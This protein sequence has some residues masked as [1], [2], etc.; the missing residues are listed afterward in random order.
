MPSTPTTKSQVQAY[1]FVLRRMESALVRK[2]PVMLHEPLRS[3]AR[4]TLAG[5]CLAMVIT[6]GFLVF[7]VI[8]Q[9]PSLPTDNPRIVIAEPSGSIYVF[10]PNSRR[11][12]PVFNLASAR[13]LLAALN[14]N[15]QVSTDPKV[16]GDDQLQ[17]VSMGKLTGIPDGPQVLP[18][19]GSPAADWA[20]CDDARNGKLQTTVLAGVSNIGTTLPANQ[21]LLVTGPDGKTYLV[22]QRPHDVNNPDDSPVRAEVDVTD[23]KVWSALGLPPIAQ[24]RKI[25]GA[26]LNAIPEVGQITNP[27]AK[28]PGYGQLGPVA[29]GGLKVGDSYQVVNVGGPTYYY[30]VVSTTSVE[31]VTPTV[32]QIVRYVEGQSG[33]M[34]TMPGGLV[35]EDRGDP[36]KV[37]SYPDLIPEVSEDSTG[38]V[39]CLGWHADPT[40]PNAPLAKTWVTVDN[41]VEL[42]TVAGDK[43]SPTPIGMPSPDGQRID[44]FFMRSGAGLTVRAASNTGE[45][46]SGPIYVVSSRGVKYSVQDLRTA[47]ELGVANGDSGAHFGLAPAPEAILRLLP[48]GTQTLNTQNVLHTYDT[49]P[50]PQN[51]G[52]Y[53]TPPP[54]AANGSGG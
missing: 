25:S 46:W 37:N 36:L 6:V 11:L 54:N 15:G 23:P 5:V 18:A 47:Q 12:T 26:L 44:W 21:G 42:P 51:A 8:R 27:V 24:A 53:M 7:A 34:T 39:M 16:V 50:M 22:Y 31:K 48:N 41:Q 9:D 49:V 1:R 28:L 3:H 33:P 32:V 35:A 40:N 29:L 30:V 10:T 19:P 2:D 43:M 20:V 17:D 13:L 38:P 4:A 52:Q 14:P 45:F